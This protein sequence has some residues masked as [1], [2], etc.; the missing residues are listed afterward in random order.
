MTEIRF[1]PGTT[2]EFFISQKGGA[3]NHFRLD[4]DMAMFLRRYTVPG[5]FAA[6]DCG[7]ISFAFDP[8]YAT[9]KLIYTGHCTAANRSKLARFTVSE[10]LTDPV[11]ILVFNEPQ[12]PGLASVGSIGFD[13]KKNLW[14]LHGEF[15]DA[16]NAQN[17]MSNLGK[18]LRLVP[19]RVAGMGGATP[20]AGNMPGG[21][22]LI[23]AY[24]LRSPWRGSSTA[25]DAFWSVTWDRP[26]PKR[27]TSSPPPGRTSG[28]TAP[29]WAPAT[30]CTGLTNPLTAFRNSNDPYD[31]MGN[32]AWEARLG[33]LSGSA[34]STST[35]GTTSTAA[36]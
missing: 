31:G 24:G 16:T 8:D 23:Y 1:V 3:I 22:G 13:P 15:T 21:T 7:L 35:A 14:M 12:R 5:V 25:R 6:E 11:D 27:S 18:L 33:G 17:L 36:R 19:S 32:A 30:N 28:G 10:M 2:N 9:N 34:P 29:A 4:G 26:P 20:A